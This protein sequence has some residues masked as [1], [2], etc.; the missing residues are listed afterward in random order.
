[1]KRFLRVLM[2]LALMALPVTSC[3]DDS[4]IRARLEDHERRLAALD[5]ACA[6]RTVTINSYL[7]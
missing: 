1:M 2:T 7:T 6:N 5:Q 3:Y 4:E